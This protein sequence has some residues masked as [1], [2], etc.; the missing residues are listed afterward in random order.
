MI[1]IAKSA[2]DMGIVTRDAAPM[3]D[4]YHG[5]LGLPL[6]GEIQIPGTGRI[7][8]L[9][10]GD[11]VIKLFVLDRAP[12]ADRP[13][14]GYLSTSGLRYFTIT[15]GNIRETI[16]ACRRAGVG[17]VTDIVQPRPGLLAAMIADPDGNT[18]ELME[19]S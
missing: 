11:S 9:Q 17:I 16:E 8:R 15:I 12:C 5:L 10:C 4:F 14:D 18:I 6:A 3:V 1:R 2:I 19:T 7:V 13:A